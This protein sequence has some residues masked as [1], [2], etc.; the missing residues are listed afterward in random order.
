MLMDIVIGLVVIG[1]IV[2]IVWIARHPPQ[3]AG[4][5][6]ADLANVL[7]AASSEAWEAVKR[8]LPGIVS[9]EVTQLRADLAAALERARKAETD[10]AAQI[11]A[12]ND[13]LAS[14][15]AR[16]VAVVTS[17]PELPPSPTPP[18]VAA[19]QAADAARVST[20]ADTITPQQ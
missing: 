19:A 2:G 18:A 15:A 13:A 1:V 14:V 17:A 6:T 10:L 4:P 20:F 11:K 12:H 7:G 5:K 16:V 8:D 3:A 9:A